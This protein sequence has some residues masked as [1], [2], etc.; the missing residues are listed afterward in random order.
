MM[1]VCQARIALAATPSDRLYLAG[2]NGNEI[3]WGGHSVT[4][5]WWSCS[6]SNQ[7]LLPNTIYFVY[8]YSA[9]GKAALELS[10]VGHET[11][12]NWNECKIGNS[13]RLLVGMV[14]T[15]ANGMF[16]RDA[17]NATVISWHN[18]MSIFVAPPAGPAPVSG[19]G[20]TDYGDIS[21]NKCKVLAWGPLLGNAEAIVLGIS[22]SAKAAIGSRCDI[23]FGAAELGAVGGVSSWIVAESGKW[24]NV[25]SASTY[26]LTEGIHEL[27]FFARMEHGS[28]ADVR[29]NGFANTWG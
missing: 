11:T 9:D 28:A 22:G 24:E 6:I 2:F 13:S 19:N 15:D 20:W 27:T 21:L 12:P 5:P 26:G 3:A 23:V 29:V 4:V 7:E 17:Q 10:R 14:Y 25:S 18:R 8:V 16:R 1:S